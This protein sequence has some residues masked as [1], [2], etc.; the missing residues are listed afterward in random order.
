M[1]YICRILIICVVLISFGNHAS[2]LVIDDPFSYFNV[3]SLSGIGD[4]NNP[5]STDFEGTTGAAGDVYFKNFTGSN[6]ESNEYVL[7]TGGYTYLSYGSYW[8]DIDVGGDALM[9]NLYIDADV[10]AGGNVGFHDGTITGNV[11][12]AGSINYWNTGLGASQV[13]SYV[14]YTPAVDHVAMKDYFGGTSSAIGLMSDTGSITDYYG[15]LSVDAVSGTNVFSINAAQLNAA[16]KITITGP[17][18]AVVYINV[19]GTEADLINLPWYYQGGIAPNDVLVNYPFASQLDLLGGMTVNILAPFADTYF[20]N[21][22]VTGNLIV[23]NLSGGAQVNSG[24]FGHGPSTDSS[25][26]PVPEPATMLL[27]GTGCIGVIGF[28]NK[29]RAS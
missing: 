4:I 8:G 16:H 29:L 14:P 17:S 26:N 27:L 18:D 11:T 3:Y 24:Y 22:L 23:G 21:G 2:A 13:N 7:H 6:V 5:F 15:N 1:I 28:R 10:I 9:H 25:P 12:A 20:D 19:L